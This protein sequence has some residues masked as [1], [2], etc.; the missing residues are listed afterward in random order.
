MIKP[1]QTAGF[2]ILELVAI[3]ATITTLTAIASTSFRSI[4]SDLENDEVHA[5]LNS[6]AYEC[7]E[8]YSRQAGNSGEIPTPISTNINLINKNNYKQMK[9]N[10]CK[11]FQI[12]PAD[13]RSKTHYT[14]GFGIAHNKVTKFAIKDSENSP[15]IVTSCEGWAGAENCLSHGENYKGFFNH[16]ETVRRKQ[17]ACDINLKS[18]IEKNPDPVNGGNQTVWDENVSRDCRKKTLPNSKNQ[19]SY[20]SNCKSN[21]CTK[22]VKIKDGKIVGIGSQATNQYQEYIRSGKA[23][24]C[25]KKIR[26]YVENN[27]NHTGKLT[28]TECE[29]LNGKSASVYICNGSQ[30]ENEREYD[31]CKIETEIQKCTIEL[32]RLRRDAE[33]GRHIVGKSDGLKGLPPCGREVWIYDGVVYYEPQKE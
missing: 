17:A 30:M 2:S 25:D 10:S 26:D 7:L 4:F 21:G 22:P 3:V 11:Y 15:D 6:L 33:P 12:D 23:E 29:D 19:N 13:I 16:M 8:I 31:A 1:A 18:Y 28:F 5:H 9:G 27:P 24:A 32:D 20:T 14:M